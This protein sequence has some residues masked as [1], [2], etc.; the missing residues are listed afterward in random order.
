M[1][2]KS[3][4][5]K[6]ALQKAE[7][8]AWKAFSLYVRIRDANNNG[9]CRCITSG[10]LVHWKDCDAG[11]FISRRHKATKFHE[12]NVHAQSRHDNRFQNGRQMEYAKIIDMK[13]G[14]G[15]ADKLLIQSRKA[16]H[17][18]LVDYVWMAEHYEKE[19]NKLADAKGIVI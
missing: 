13:Y 18:G 8:K 11:H 15:T 6:S 10:R 19:A 7:A 12:Q 5:P 17:R 3:K 14:P 2:I 1:W 4:K 9:Y 16:C